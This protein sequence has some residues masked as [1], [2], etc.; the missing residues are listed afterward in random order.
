M[1]VAV[2]SL[3]SLRSSGACQGRRPHSKRLIP[4]AQRLDGSGLVW[5]GCIQSTVD[6]FLMDRFPVPPALFSGSPE[7]VVRRMR[8]P[9]YSVAM[10]GTPYRIA[11][12][13]CISGHRH[14]SALIRLS[15]RHRRE[16]L[17]VLCRLLDAVGADWRHLCDVDNQPLDLGRY[18]S[19]AEAS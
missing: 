7:V 13:R 17:A 4:I 18:C 5:I 6:L 11:Y 8:L 2:A 16:T 15:D 12:G 1:V 10:R 14:Q 19:L 9:Q 3:A